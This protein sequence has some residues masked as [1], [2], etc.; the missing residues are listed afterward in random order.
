MEQEDKVMKI[1]SFNNKSI[2]EIAKII[3]DA[4][5]EVR[6]APR[7]DRQSPNLRLP[8][9]ARRGGGA[10]VC[11]WEMKAHFHRKD[12]KTPRRKG[13]PSFASLRLCAFAFKKGGLA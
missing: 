5:I 3:E 10:V 2:S 7:P 13:F 6:V 4:A 12:A 11:A 9:C 8:V 1:D